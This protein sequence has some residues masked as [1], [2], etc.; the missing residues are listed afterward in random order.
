MTLCLLTAVQIQVGYKRI[1]RGRVNNRLDNLL[2]FTPGLNEESLR[3]TEGLVEVGDG[4]CV[5]RWSN[6]A[7]EG[8]QLG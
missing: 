5:P 6:A 3:M 7:E 1:V 2:Q 8:N 4:K